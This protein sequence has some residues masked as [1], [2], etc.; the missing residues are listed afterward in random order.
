MA[1]KANAENGSIEGAIA[2]FNERMQIATAPAWRPSTGDTLAYE[3]IGLKMGTTTDYAPYPII[4]AKRMDDGTPVAIHAFHTMLRE[5]LRDLKCDIGK[6]FI[7]S[8]LG[9][10]VKNKLSAK[11]EQ[12]TYHMYYTE[13]I[14][15][16]GGP[17]EA[18]EKGFTFD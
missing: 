17:V 9:E 3:V 2:Q 16:D 10:Q 8:Y 7:T 13:E 1:N 6:R 5:G 14:N 11:G 12:E 4:V 18:V 15:L